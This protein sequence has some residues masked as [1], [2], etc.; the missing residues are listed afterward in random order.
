MFFEVLFYFSC[1][2]CC[3]VAVDALF[4]SF[5]PSSVVISFTFHL[6]TNFLLV[7]SDAGDLF[8]F[9]CDGDLAAPTSK[10]TA[11]GVSATQPPQSVWTRSPNEAKKAD[12]AFMFW[13]KAPRN[14]GKQDKLARS[15]TFLLRFFSH[16]S[17][18]IAYSLFLSQSSSFPMMTLWSSSRSMSTKQHAAPKDCL[19]T[20]SKAAHR[21]D[22]LLC[23][24]TRRRRLNAIGIFWLVTL[25]N[26]RL[27]HPP[28]VWII[29]HLN[30]NHSL[31]DTWIFWRVS[32]QRSRSSFRS[33]R[34]AR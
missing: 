22:V 3:A 32:T 7:S 15:S 11:A 1:V 5:C 24:V 19:C 9:R 28:S 27:P 4:V 21:R 13:T 30:A 29:A 16:P 17:S 34:T 31:T 8:A 2:S 12:K 6:H 20:I 10:R 23:S 14:Q 18:P 25:L 26:F 33:L